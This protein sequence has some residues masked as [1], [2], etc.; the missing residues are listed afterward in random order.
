MIKAVIF[1]LGGVIVPF[2]FTIGY[3]QLEP[4]CEI[5]AAD[6]PARIAATGLVKQLE[7]GQISA[8]GFYI[9]L[10][11]A[12]NLQ[13]TIEEFRE[14]WCSVFQTHTLVPEE[15][16]ESIARTHRLIL[17]SNTNSIHFDMILK[18]YPALRHFH[19]HVL[20][21]EA[22]FLKPEPEIYHAAIATAGCTAE[23]C[24]FTDDLAVNVEGAKQ[25]GMDA[26]VFESAS[27]LE[28]ELQA[29]GIA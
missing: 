24:F 27:Q 4:L 16:L 21:H 7:S 10:A 23:E 1:D 17:L 15:L 9:R 13:I 11:D 18:A 14:I 20:S 26:V 12:L 6:L 25:V 5:A 3:K 29:R 28:A 19:A 8:D 22:G 2:D